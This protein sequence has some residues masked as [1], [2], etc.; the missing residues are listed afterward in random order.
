MAEAFAL[1]NGESL[2][3]EAT[4]TGKITSVD[5]AYSATSGDITVSISVEGKT[6]KCYR[7]KGTGVDKIKV[8]DTITVKGK[9]KNYNGTIEFDNAA[10]TAVNSGA[11][12]APGTSDYSLTGLVIIMVMATATLVVVSKKKFYC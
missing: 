8:G 7:L 1:K 9:I 3:Y 11:N 4:L 6:L 5:Y 12:K 10:L 2:S